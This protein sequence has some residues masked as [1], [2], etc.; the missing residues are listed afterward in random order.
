MN[1]RSLATLLLLV[2]LSCLQGQNDD[3][4]AIAPVEFSLHDQTLTEPLVL[5][6][7]CETEG[8]VI[9]YSTDGKPLT[10]FN[11][12]V[13]TKP[14]TINGT[15]WIRAQA[16]VSKE[17]SVITSGH[18]VHLAEDVRDF[19]S[20]LP[21]LVLENFGQGRVPS[22]DWNQTGAG[23]QQVARQRAQ[24]FLFDRDDDDG[25]S[26]FRREP[27]QSARLGVRVRGA[28]SSSFP[29]KPFSVEAWDEEDRETAIRPLGMPAESDWIL[30]PP[31]AAQDRT[32]LYNT[33]LYELS[34]SLGGNGMRFRFTEAFVHTG[35]GS[36]SMDD[37]AGVYVILEKVKRD[38]SRLDFPKLSEDGTEGGWLLSINRMDPVPVDGYPTTN[39]ATEP[40]FFHTAGPNRNLQT[41]P[42]QAGRGDDVPRQGNAFLNF[43][44][45]NGYTINEA[46]RAAIEGWFET[47]EDVLYSDDFRDPVNGYRRYVDVDSF[48]DYFILHDITRNTDGLLIS[49]W[50]YKESPEAK[51]KMGP[52]WDYDLAYKS[53]ATSSLGLNRDRLWYTR[54]WQDPDFEQRYMDRWQELRAGPM[55]DEAI[56]AR[57]DNQAAEITEEVAS[58]HGV[59]DWPSRLATWKKW[60]TDRAAAIDK[61]FEPRPK[62]VQPS[63]QVDEGTRISLKAGTIFSPRDIYF[64]THGTDPRAAGGAVSD[65]AFLLGSSITIDATTQVSARV[66]DGG[67]WSGLV[68]AWYF[69]EAQPAS[70]ENLRISKIHYHPSN[71]TPEEIEA[72]FVNDD[73]FEFL[74]LR[75]LSEHTVNLG[76]SQFSDGIDFTFGD[77]PIS[78]QARLLLVRNRE[79]FEH[80]YG[81]ALPVVGEYTGNLRNSGESLRLLDF[82]GSVVEE[83]EFNDRGSWPRTADGDGPSLVRMDTSSTDSFAWRPSVLVHGAPGID[84]RPEFE[85]DPYG[86]DDDDGVSNL[87]EFA[88]GPQPSI[89]VSWV[90]GASHAHLSYQRHLAANSE[91]FVEASRDLLRWDLVEPVKVDRRYLT[92]GAVEEWLSIPK[93]ASGVYYRLRVDSP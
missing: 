45:P 79:A 76:G 58:R 56:H 87:I 33:W 27:N 67:I 6:L 75:N 25:L 69:V 39:G 88:L 19:E 60:I 49:M 14:L 3:V 86:D 82:G 8:A 47:F 4:E 68:E 41:S 78:P 13:Y 30:Y 11:S 71:P 74:E 43:E 38:G 1:L 36:L 20:P 62:V 32:L 55:S 66:L 22:K 72:G 64:T 61:Q 18:Y 83:I 37:H 84:D 63:G 29:R 5:E 65:R 10:L 23:V 16:S 28:F 42:N 51:L 50:V 44:S 31:N 24:W 89:R 15:T 40:Q 53:T 52:V 80:R 73:D 17:S 90:E 35:G 57:I 92:S 46:Q 12:I 91:I 7:S 93:N 21:I 70:A 2:S 9:R 48:I 77:H 59:G 34:R 54:L 81:K 85:G 26:R